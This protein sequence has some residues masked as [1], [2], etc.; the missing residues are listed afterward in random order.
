[1]LERAIKFGWKLSPEK[2]RL[3]K[4]KMEF[5]GF[6]ISQ[7]GISPELENDSM[8]LEDVQLTVSPLEKKQQMVR[9]RTDS[10]G[11]YESFPGHQ[12]HPS[13][14]THHQKPK[15]RFGL[16]PIYRKMGQLGP[17]RGNWAQ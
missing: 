10:F 12:K 14:C 5:L 9:K 4:D 15:V 2:C 8:F 3:A 16:P 1:M 17:P 11:H 13:E 6:Q 7:E